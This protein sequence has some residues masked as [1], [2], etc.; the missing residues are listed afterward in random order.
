MPISHGDQLFGL[1]QSLTKAEKRNFRLYARRIQG[2]SDA[3]FMQLFDLLEKQ[4]EFHE[5]ALL[6]KMKGA[7]KSQFSNLKRHLY[8]HILTSLRL[9]EM[10][11]REEIQVREWMD[12]ADILY[13]KGLY[14]QAL[15]LLSKAKTLAISMNHDLLHLEIVEFEKRIESRHIT[16]STTERMEG[17]TEEA[18]KRSQINAT[19]VELSNFKLILQRR[20]INFGHVKS[21]G[22]RQAAERF[23]QDHFPSIRQSKPTFF[24]EVYLCQVY[25]WQHYLLGEYARCL[26]FAQQWVRLYDR[27]ARMIDPDVDMYLIGLNHLLVS[28]FS[29]RDYEV[30]LDTLT[31]LE[32]FRSGQYARLNYNSKIL[33]FLAVH[34][35]R[36]NLHFL[37]G[38]FQEGLKLIPRT[39]RR[40]KIYEGRLD[41][42]KVLILYYKIAWMYMGAG[43]PGSAIDYLNKILNAPG[44]SLR[45][46]LQAYTQLLFIM[47]HYDL[48]N[49]DMLDYRIQNTARFIS[50]MKESSKLQKEAILFF[51]A[52]LS[53]PPSA[54]L[55]LFEGFGAQLAEYRNDPYEQ[56]AFIFLDLPAWVDAKIQDLPLAAVVAQRFTCRQQFAGK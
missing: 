42:H 25:Y 51:R 15:K 4:K 23:F 34:Q 56:R 43:Q 38:S 54:R 20:F 47:A 10:G 52:L 9:L 37:E 17:L 21:A 24:E 1:V 3:K 35:G 32:T 11:K 33:S 44:K 49:F 16:R 29:L 39:L 45:E 28:S 18:Q 19:I 12:Y 7:S 36:Y 50:Q 14:L 53:A 27:D 13:G 31:R 48:G 40:L 41:P 22:D 46:D 6:R 2:E 8:Q 26:E 5:E 30:F 55:A